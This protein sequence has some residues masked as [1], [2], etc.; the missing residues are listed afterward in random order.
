MPPRSLDERP[1]PTSVRVVLTGSE[2]TGK[3]ALAREI[4]IRLGVPWVPE[5]AREYASR[6]G[7]PLRAADVDAIAHGQIALEDAVLALNPP[8]VV[9]DT[10][11]VSTVVYARHYYGECPDWIVTAAH[12][13]L[14]TLYLLLDTDIMWAADGVRDRP[15][16]R[17][18]IQEL[19][20]RQLRE[21]GADI[22][23]VSGLGA[24]RLQMALQVI[25]RLAA[26]GDR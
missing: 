26:P 14:G 21:F 9:F 17:A 1:A 22:A 3:S 5:Y 4:A 7:R 6:V 13:R 23:E 2:S 25:Q 16:R 8:Q 11:L 24:A 18:E 15:E 19:F 10:D 12:A 20:R